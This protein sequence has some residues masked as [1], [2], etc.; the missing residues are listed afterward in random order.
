MTNN[1]NSAMRRASE[2]VRAGNPTAATE[3]IQ[4]ALGAGG[5][6]R[7]SRHGKTPFGRAKIGRGLRATL[8][9]LAQSAMSGGD[10]PEPS[11]PDGARFD[12]GTFSCAAGS[13]DYRLYI[14][15]LKGAPAAGLVM[16][17]HGCKQSPV[18]FA[19]G[20]G[21]N[22]LAD[23]HGLILVYPAQICS[24][25]GT[26]SDPLTRSATVASQLFWPVSCSSC[27][28]ITT[29]PKV[30]VLLPVCLLVLPW[31][32]CWDRPMQMF[33]TRSALIPV[34]PLKLPKMCHRPLRRW[35]RVRPA[36]IRVKPFPRLFFRAMQT[37][38]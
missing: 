7:L 38:R 3:A 4:A 20:T 28:A 1:F 25:A 13:R 15:D 2:L 16:L 33:L 32:S 27:N 36:L 8:A 18:D 14:P 37:A 17:L 35:G 21:M 24:H 29:Y 19:K 5:A 12:S 31:L 23:E 10:G 26:G 30:E 9:G 22:Q 34:C 6:G 11:L